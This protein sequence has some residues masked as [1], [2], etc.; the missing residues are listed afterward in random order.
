MSQKQSAGRW[1]RE[2]QKMNERLAQRP[3]LME[4]T[5]LEQAKERARQRA[6]LRVRTE[7]EDRGVR[8]VDEHFNLEE[9]N[10]MDDARS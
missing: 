8:N 6:L 2:I 4:R 5:Q 3:L 9:L 1:A 7:L 10:I